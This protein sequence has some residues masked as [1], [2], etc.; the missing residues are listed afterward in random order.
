M[1]GVKISPFP[2][3]P[4]SARPV[5]EEDDDACEKN[6]SNGNAKIPISLKGIAGAIGGSLDP[7]GVSLRLSLFPGE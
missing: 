5:T 3:L 2:A 4:Q 6:C 1:F 7:S